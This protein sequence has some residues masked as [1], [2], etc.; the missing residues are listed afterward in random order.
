MELTHINEE[1]RARMVDV[2]EKL[3]TA[4]EAVAIGTVSM[5]RETIERIKEGT[6]SKGDV[7]S[8]AQVGGIMGAKNT[9]QIIPMCHPIMI[10]GC[11]ISFRID[12]ENNKIEI[13][14][15]TKTVGKTGIEMEALTAVSTAALTI[16]DMCKAID[17]EMV[18]NNIMLVKKSG[19]K[20]GIFER[21]GL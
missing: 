9:P 19:G 12:V 13:T 14:A 18:I 5:K 11:D 1:G 4:R 3:D 20:S 2:S 16:Y 7:L 21:K 6:I 10:S 8:V 15:T 17:R